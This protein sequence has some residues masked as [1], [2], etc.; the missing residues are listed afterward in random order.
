[1]SLSP[2]SYIKQV[3]HIYEE[4]IEE[5]SQCRKYE[6]SNVNAENITNE[7]AEGTAKA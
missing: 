4:K 5:K 6:R 7:E 3:F 1:M 2:R